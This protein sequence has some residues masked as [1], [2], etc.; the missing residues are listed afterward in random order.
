MSSTPV[1]DSQ[2][3]FALLR[4]RATFRTGNKWR[5]RNRERHL[6]RSDP[7]RGSADDNKPSNATSS[8]A[9]QPTTVLSPQVHTRPRRAAKWGGAADHHH[10]HGAR[11]RANDPYVPPQRSHGDVQGNISNDAERTPL[12][13]PAHLRRRRLPHQQPVQ[14]IPETRCRTQ[15]W[16]QSGEDTLPRRIELERGMAC[17]TRGHWRPEQRHVCGK[18]VQHRS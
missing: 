6:R 10:A 11:Q 16:L 18:K 2:T 13:A 1:V 8:R 4:S 5:D 7:P 14:I 15:F 17:E 12:Q 3:S 9:A